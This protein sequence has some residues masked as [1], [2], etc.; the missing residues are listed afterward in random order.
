MPQFTT[1]DAAELAAILTRHC[2][3]PHPDK[4]GWR[5]RCPAH[6]GASNTSLSLVPAAD[7]VL[8]HCF[9]GC[10]P[11]AIV[12]AMGLPL[13]AL[14]LQPRQT[15]GLGKIQAI[16]DYHAA[17]GTL[18]FQVVRYAPK[19]FR[20]RRPNPARPGEY[21]YNLQG[22]EPVLYRLPELLEA[23][24]A[25]ATL[26]LPEG[27]KDVD[28]LWALGLAATCNPMGAGKW[29]DRYSETLRGAQ[30]VL[31]P[32]NDAPGRQHAQ[33]V[34]RALHGIAASVKVVELPGLPV[35]GDVSDWLASGG[36]KEALEALVASTSAW[37][38]PLTNSAPAAMQASPNGPLPYSDAYNAEVLARDAGR[39]LRYCYPWKSWLIWTGTHWQ[40]DSSGEVMRRARHTLR[41]LLTR[42]QTLEDDAQLRELLKHIKSSLSNTRLKGM[43]EQ[44]QSMRGMPATPDDFDR[45]GWV[46]NCRNGTLDLRTGTLRAHDRADLLTKCLDVDYDPEAQ[47][48]TWTAFLARILD[49]NQDLRRFLQRAVG[50]ALT[51][52]TSEHCLFILYGTGRNGKSTL[53]DTMHALLGSYATQAEMSTFLAKDHDT[54]RNDLADLHGARLVSAVEVSEGRRLA[55]SLVKQLTGGD[56]IKARFLFQ[57]HF[58]FTPQLKLFL[59]C[60]HKPVIRGTDVAM[61]ERIR[62]VPFTVTIPRQE[63]DKKLL[64]KLRA[65]VSG[66]LSWALQGCLDWQREG[67]GEPQ[68][69]EQATAGYRAEMDVM[70]QFL[71][72]RCLVDP[73]VRVQASALFQAYQ[74]WCTANGEH[75]VTQTAFGR[76][77]TERAFAR[78]RAS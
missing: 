49:G 73:Q 2:E 72:E 47:C 58:A 8:L 60:N 55:E 20:Q 14:F 40:R 61:W 16:Y 71:D 63:R 35:K 48:P 38:P 26:H 29:K 59:A 75:A 53:L 36:T 24:H 74:A 54:V 33:Q 67:L 9:A 64:E 44:T 76:K 45:D 42:A 3:D 21:L 66:I 5:A 19:T 11:T 41:G 32:D 37:V 69:V 15:N 7:R 4:Q 50:Y 56:R 27:E 43:V 57:E 39:D 68:E 31:C 78:K 28:A 34:A 10:T 6:Q 22:I 52:D 23:V 51:G 65:E 1:S 13:A 77:L 12:Q 46:L 25:G 70:G 17:D 30:V 18:L 62:L